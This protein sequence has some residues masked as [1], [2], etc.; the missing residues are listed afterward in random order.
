[1]F[2]ITKHSSIELPL[3]QAEKQM[4]A[5]G[6][7]SY[8]GRLKLITHPQPRS[9]NIGLTSHTQ[10]LSLQGDIDLKSGTNNVRMF[11]GDSNPHLSQNLLESHTQNGV[12][13]TRLGT[14]DWQIGS[15]P[16]AAFSADGSL[17]IYLEAAHHVSAGMPEQRGGIDLT[18][19]TFD[20][21]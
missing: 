1:F 20:V 2:S 13:R 9:E 6:A 3:L 15:T 16:L 5:H 8:D 11:K 10:D 14:G 19:Y 4:L 12:V 18:R 7:Y 21:D 17:M